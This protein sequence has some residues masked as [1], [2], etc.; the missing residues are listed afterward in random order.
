MEFARGNFIDNQ[1][2]KPAGPGA[3]YRI[4]VVARDDRSEWESF[5]ASP[6]AAA[7]EGIIAFV[8]P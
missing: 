5:H 7:A 3:T 4:V 6:G 1:W 8:A 2:V